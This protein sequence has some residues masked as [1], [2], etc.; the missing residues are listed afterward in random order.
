MKH[1]TVP[2]H[3]AGVLSQLDHTMSYSY[4]G[5]PGKSL[6]QIV[7]D[8]VVVHTDGVVIRKI[9]GSDTDEGLV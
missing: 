4:P 7:S 3:H 1:R 2:S 9:T 8:D 5:L 6:T